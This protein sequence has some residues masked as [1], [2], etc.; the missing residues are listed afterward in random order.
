MGTVFETIADR[1][2]QTEDP[3]D[4]PDCQV[5]GAI[6]PVYV[7]QG[8][9]VPG[10]G[11]SAEERLVYVACA[12]CI[13]GGRVEQD[14]QHQIEAGA[15]RHAVRPEEAFALLRRTPPLAHFI[16]RF[17][18]PFCCGEPAELTGEPTPDEAAELD[19]NGRYWE[20]GPATA[21]TPAV[22]LVPSDRLAVMGGVSAFRCRTC[23]TFSWTFQFS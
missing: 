23:G 15:R 19:R 13:R 1:A 7:C 5:C 18:W 11:E 21:R 22:D 9:A 4:Y 8:R 12:D 2:L 14:V 20:G 17:D 10:P 3:A 16:Q 6:A